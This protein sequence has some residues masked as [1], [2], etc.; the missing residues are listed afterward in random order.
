MLKE[1]TKLFPLAKEVL[2]E[3]EWQLIDEAV[4]AIDDPVFDEM[5]ADD[6]QRLYR[7]MTAQ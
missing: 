3:T 4:N 2:T 7:L 1:E 5:T 6:Y